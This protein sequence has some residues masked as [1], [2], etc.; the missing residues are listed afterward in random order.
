L[1]F[2]TNYTFGKVL[3]FNSAILGGQHQNEAGTVLNR[4]NIGLSKG[5][6]SYSVA[7]R[8]NTSFSYQLP[9]GSGKFFG[10]GATGWV[11]KVIGGW[12]WNGSVSAQSGFPI[13]PLFG[14]NNTGDGN[15][16][17][18]DVPNRNPEF[19]GKAILGV[20]GFKKTGRYFDPN[21]FSRPLAGTYGNVGRGVFY[22]PGLVNV[23]TS[24][25]K[26]IPLNERWNLQFRTEFFNVLNHANFNNPNPIVFQGTAVSPTAGI[27]TETSSDGNGRQIQFALRL[28]F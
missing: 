9:F 25:F 28:E 26:D 11:D 19:Q 12:Q 5:V 21:A 10:G 3:D 27:I 13:L 7:H 22:G 6:A 18:P 14:S 20:D 23:N 8:S 16:R 4:F 15:Q 17:N 1:T 24:F 2:K